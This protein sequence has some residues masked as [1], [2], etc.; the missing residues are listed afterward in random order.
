MLFT[1]SPAPQQA[2]A[3]EPVV[4]TEEVPDGEVTRVEEV[5]HL[6]ETNSETYRLS[7]GRYECVVFAEDKYFRNDANQLQLIDN[8][9]VLDTQATAD[10]NQVYKNAAN[11]FDVSFGSEAPEVSIFQDTAGVVFTPVGSSGGSDHISTEEF[12]FLVGPVN[13]CDALSQLTY[14]GSNTVTYANAFPNTDLVY[15]LD[16]SALK[17]YIIL[18]NRYSRLL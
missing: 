14:T 5:L 10:A 12:D 7:D 16:N 8:S 2:A 3:V 15:V 17:E 9:I 6:R 11:F 4:I 13:N 18:E 1:L